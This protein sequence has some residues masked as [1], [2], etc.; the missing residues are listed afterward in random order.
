MSGS[1]G[2]SRTRRAQSSNSS[3]ALDTFE[4]RRLMSAS[5][6]G[7]V[8]QDL[9]ANGHRDTN[10]P[11]L[12]NVKVYVDLNNDGVKQDTEPQS[13]TDKLGKF[14]FTN[15]TTAVNL[16]IRQ[17]LPRG[18]VQSAPNSNYV[19]KVKLA[20]GQN[21][22]DLAYGDTY[23]GAEWVGLGGN[24]SHAGASP[25]ESQ[26]LGAIH[27]QTTI[28]QSPPTAGGAHYGSPV[29]SR[30]GI[31]FVP[32]KT[33][34]AGGF[35]VVAMRVADGTVLW[36]QAS[37]YTLPP[38]GKISTFAPTLTRT[39][40]LYW[41]GAGGTVYYMEHADT[42][43]PGPVKHI[44]FYGMDKYNQSKAAYDASLQINTPITVDAAGNI[45]FGYQATGDNPKHLGGGIARLALN[46][47]GTR[48]AATD[49]AGDATVNK[50]VTDAAPA[51]S[52]DGTTLYVVV[53]RAA[54][55]AAVTNAKTYLLA[56]DATT[57]ALKHKIA[58]TDP[59]SGAAVTIADG[60]A[61]SPTIAP[62]GDIYFGVAENTANSTHGRGWLL[63]FSADL[64]T[65]KTPASF[66]FD[67]TASIV[68]ASMVPS[69]T[70]TSAYLIMT[71]YND[72]VAHGGTGVNKLAI[73]DPAATQTDAVTGKTVMKEVS[74]IAGP[75]ADT[76]NT[77]AHPGAAKA[78]SVGSAVVDPATNSVIANS[79][80]GVLY[81]W[82]VKTNTLTQNI[83]LTPG[84][85]Q[86]PT[87]TAIAPDGTL[88]AISEGK[89]F[90]I[91]KA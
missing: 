91:G 87:V 76:T 2:I 47:R 18:W 73:L 42:P 9:A 1:R 77:T 55:G 30:T 78:W 12:P 84:K 5:A 67:E 36:E 74:T 4:D 24:A 28:D 17:V 33:T 15:L 60:P 7:V 89:L 8:F 19:I 26:G 11:G 23:K 58:L 27:W 16:A 35:K 32:V 54:G 43:S 71:R 61:S 22:T 20:Q 90:A 88:F 50:L 39:G 51:L 37:D 6:S 82:D 63:R 31:A 83:R 13:L 59:K 25:V 66:G 52:A 41:P 53:N 62:D 14:S 48:I 72:D 85:A 21:R 79:E 29:F 80:D 81:R 3:F 40:R 34:A 75:T 45:F 56:L 64:Q 49:A 57:L 38:G 86:V 10:E 69:Y 70:G 68:P 65:T 46:S 44:A